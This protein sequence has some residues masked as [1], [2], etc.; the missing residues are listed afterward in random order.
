[1][2]PRLRH[3]LLAAETAADSSAAFRP[4]ARLSE[5]LSMMEWIATDEDRITRLLESREFADFEHWLRARYFD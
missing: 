5:A 4:S 1:M 3:A 2:Q